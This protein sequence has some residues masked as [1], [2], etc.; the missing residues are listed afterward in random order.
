VKE[1]APNLMPATYSSQ[2]SK[3]QINDLIEYMKSLK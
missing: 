2:L 1:F 3:E